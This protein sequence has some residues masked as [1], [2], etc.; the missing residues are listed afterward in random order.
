M[1]AY[2]KENDFEFWH[3]KVNQWIIDANWNDSEQLQKVYINAIARL[4]SSH[5]RSD[6]TEV[7]LYH[8][9]VYV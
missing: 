4:R 2:V 1:I 8:F 9:W 3:H 5:K 7:I 6:N